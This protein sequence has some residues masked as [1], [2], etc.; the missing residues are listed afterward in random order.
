MADIQKGTKGLVRALKE[1]DVELKGSPSV[2]GMTAL[3][4]PNYVNSMRSTMFT[5]HLKQYLNL[6]EPDFPYIFTNNENMVGKY[7]SGYKKAKNKL[8]IIKKIVKYE[9]ILEH[10][11]VYVLIVYDEEN[12]MYDIIERKICESLTENFGYDYI[13][14]KID[15]YNEGDEIDKDTVLIRS[16]SYDEDMN[17][18]YGANVNVA[19]TLD[20]FTS[21]DAAI[22]SE[23]LA[24]KMTSIETEEIAIYINNNDYLLNLYGDEKH[25]QPL[26]EI[27]QSASYILAASRKMFTNQLLWDFKSS[28]LNNITDADPPFYIEDDSVIIDYDIY[29]NAEERN[30]NP[31]YWQ[32]NKYM[33]SQ[34]KYYKEIYKECKKIIDSGANYSQELD[35]RYARAQKMIDREM[36]WRNDDSTYGNIEIVVTYR[37]TVP[38]A[39]GSKITGR[40]G[41]KSVISLIV[42]DDKMPYTEDGRRV[43]LLL[44]LLAII[45]RTTAAPLFEIAMNN[46]SFQIRQKMMELK[47]ITAK[48]KL[49]FDFIKIFNEDQEEE[50]H[51]DYR[52][53]DRLQK[54]AYIKS[55]IED[56]IYIHWNPMWEKIPIFYRYQNLKKTYPF[57]K[58]VTTYIRK[59]GREIKMLN[60]YIIGE[61]YIL[62][63]L[64]ML[65]L[66]NCWELSS[67]QSAAK[68]LL[69]KVQ[70]LSKA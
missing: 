63:H 23:S 14:D 47:T 8:K 30:D 9:D 53:M 38:L 10:P 64:R 43:D 33:D 16:T 7:S 66:V 67:R 34:R 39:K 36:K 18:S 5:A 56:G 68:P 24:K 46:A 13:N 55:A 19:Y 57:I 70:R 49:L 41:N 60:D 58:P 25:Y 52:R 12:D 3:T 51:A 45:N 69:G 6:I 50:M 27:N 65:N 21:E 42:P 44:N 37:R 32:I 28:E 61:M 29:E 11:N 17:Y 54:E 4:Y 31:F 2:L 59:W 35:Y 62:R 20:P 26:P 22:A 15:S 40:Y 1:K 48:E